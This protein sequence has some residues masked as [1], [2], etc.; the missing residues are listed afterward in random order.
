MDPKKVELI[1]GLSWPIFTFL[2]ILYA[3]II[4]VIMQLSFLSY[5]EHHGI[6]KIVTP[7]TGDNSSQ[8]SQRSETRSPQKGTQEDTVDGNP[9]MRK[10][11]K[12]H[13]LLLSAIFVLVLICGLLTIILADKAY[14]YVFAVAGFSIAYA[15]HFLSVSIGIN[16][17]ILRSGLPARDRKQIR[18]R[19]EYGIVG[20]GMQVLAGGLIVLLSGGILLV[21]GSALL[22]GLIYVIGGFFLI[23]A[24]FRYAFK[25]RHWPS[26]ILDITAD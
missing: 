26:D 9:V 15:I 19:V 18:N 14:V 12:W 25:Q 22:T 4:A 13:W 17:V 21:T 6:K 7:E 1:L 5:K 8:I 3:G 2:S 24:I 10:R 20:S 23:W 11:P 16:G